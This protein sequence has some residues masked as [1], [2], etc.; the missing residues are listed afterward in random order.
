MNSKWFLG[1]RAYG[2]RFLDLPTQI[3]DG[4]PVFGERKPYASL[5]EL[6]TRPAVAR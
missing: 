1:L 5:V 3:I 4:M 6:A 2:L